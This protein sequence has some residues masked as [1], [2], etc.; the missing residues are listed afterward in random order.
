LR[1]RSRLFFFKI[2]GDVSLT[3][4]K[5]QNNLQCHYCG[6]SLPLPH[7]CGS[8]QSADVRT[9][10]FGTEKIEDELQL[11]FPEA[12]IDRL[13]LDSTRKKFGHEKILNKFA[14]G[15]TQILVGTQMITKGLDFENVSVVGILDADNL[16]NYPDFRSHER[17]F[18]LMSQVS[19]R[20]GRKHSQGKVV[21]QTYQPEH[22]VILKVISNDFENLFKLTLQERKFFQYPPWYRLIYITVK[23]KNRDRA[24]IAAQQLATELQK[25]IKSKILGPEFP[26]MGRIQQYYQLMIRIKLERTISPVEPKR[27]MM[28]A[29]E[30]VKHF[31]N[32]GSVLFSVDVD[33]M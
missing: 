14:E 5:F 25:T 9:K 29:I 28:E 12:V 31:E 30:K 19:G 7:S 10:G 33:P 18:Q 26:L 17:A 6:Y 22:P 23:H 13:D 27:A 8:C 11:F 3:Y 1:T 16:L 24:Q 32:N 2:E 21:V 4:H 15:K 20:A